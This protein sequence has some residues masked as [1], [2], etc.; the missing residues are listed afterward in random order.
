MTVTING[1]TG[2]DKVQDGS[3]VQAD[4]A[5]NVVGTGPAFSAYLGASSPTATSGVWTKVTFD[6]EEY[7]TNNNFASSRFTPNVAGYYVF[8]AGVTF[9]SG[10][11]QVAS[12][13]KNG[14]EYKRGNYAANNTNTE[15]VF[16]QVY[17]NGLTDY[18]EIYVNQSSGSTQTLY[19]TSATTYFQ[20]AM[21]R[22]A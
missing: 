12:L 6:T 11:L 9:T 10:V 22:A 19:G 21:V 3:I 1:S 8:N 5:S 15:I 14:V 2:I 7:D 13:Y 4:L 18:V 17:L 20:G 16:G